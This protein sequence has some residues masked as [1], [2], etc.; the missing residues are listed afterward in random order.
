MLMAELC[1]FQQRA[2]RHECERT[3]G[4]FQRIHVAAQRGED[5]FQRVSA[6]WCVVRATDLGDPFAARLLLPLVQLQECECAF[7]CN[8]HDCHFRT[9]VYWARVEMEPNC[10]IN[11]RTET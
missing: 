6:E 10:F 1:N 4:K 9:P 3:T 2:P 8:L 5:V 7:I 11:S